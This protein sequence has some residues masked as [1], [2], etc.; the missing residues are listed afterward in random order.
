MSIKYMVAVW[1][2]RDVTPGEKLVLLK[3][4]DNANDDGVA[5]PGN[6]LIS[7]DCC[8]SRRAV[9]DNLRRLEAKGI[10]EVERSKG[11][12]W[13]DTNKYQLAFKG[14]R[15]STGAESA[16]V[17]NLQGTSAESAP[18]PPYEPIN[19]NNNVPGDNPGVKDLGAAEHPRP[20]AHNGKYQS[21]LAVYPASAFTSIPEAAVEFARIA[22]G[23]DGRLHVA[24]IMSAAVKYSQHV[25]RDATPPTSVKGLQRFL[26]SEVWKNEWQ[27]ANTEKLPRDNRGRGEL[28]G[29]A[30]LDAECAAAFENDEP[31]AAGD[32]ER[33]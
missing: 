6:H 8:L 33:N 20:G 5:W 15:F 22:A 1:Q 17:Q 14:C 31:G 10:I 30:L 16:L 18:N 29:A 25:K 28:R 19:N 7:G 2:L 23:N 24:A 27:S 11:G 21:L 32:A 3:L 4:A 26:K 12:P 9:W 13:R